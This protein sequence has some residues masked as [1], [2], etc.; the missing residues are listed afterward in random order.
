MYALPLVRFADPPGA[1]IGFMPVESP[2][3]VRQFHGAIVSAEADSDEMLV[4]YIVDSALAV[5]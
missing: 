4:D 5:I 3:S 2:L 1:G